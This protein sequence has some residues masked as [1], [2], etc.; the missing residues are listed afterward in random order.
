MPGII[1][2]LTLVVTTIVTALSV[3]R[4]REAGTIEQLLVTPIRPAELLIG[5]IVPNVIVAII[6]IFIHDIVGFVDTLVATATA[7]SFGVFS[8]SCR[9]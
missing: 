4:E 5:K 8:Q 3:A 6:N 7:S 2:L 9:R 1:G